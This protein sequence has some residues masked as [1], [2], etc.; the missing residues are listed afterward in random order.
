[1]PSPRESYSYY[2][3]NQRV[4]LKMKNIRKLDLLDGDSDQDEP[5]PTPYVGTKYK[6][7]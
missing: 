2:K 4:R 7:E 1:M 5:D 3:S 6:E